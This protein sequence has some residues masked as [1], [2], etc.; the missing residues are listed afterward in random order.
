MT[1]TVRPAAES[2]LLAVARIGS[3]SFPGTDTQA[4]LRRLREHPLAKAY[5]PHSGMQLGVNIV[6]YAMTH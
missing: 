2:D 6:M 3:Q 4:R 1:L 5:E